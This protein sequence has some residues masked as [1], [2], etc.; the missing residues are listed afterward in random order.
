[1]RVASSSVRAPE[2]SV[3]KQNKPTSRG[4]SPSSK[5]YLVLLL[6]QHEITANDL[7]RYRLDTR[8]LRFQ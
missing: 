8:F 1:L 3:L 5:E 7:A 4:I 2:I 6:S